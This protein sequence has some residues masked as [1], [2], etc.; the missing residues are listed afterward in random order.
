MSSVIPLEF[1]KSLALFLYQ[2]H[3]TIDSL[4]RLPFR[5]F[6]PTKERRE[7]RG[8]VSILQLLLSFKIYFFPWI[9]I[10]IFF[11]FLLSWKESVSRA[12]MKNLRTVAY[13]LKKRDNCPAGGEVGARGRE[14]WDAE[15][16]LLLYKMVFKVWC[17]FCFVERVHYSKGEDKYSLKGLDAD[18][19]TDGRSWK[20]SFRSLLFV[21]PTRASWQFYVKLKFPGMNLL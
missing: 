1:E 5:F 4:L 10:Y 9:Y 2:F 16:F 21:T 12:R 15:E 18:R 17:A 19:G 14:E 7:H 8:G 6:G 13:D 11:S 20:V 3:A